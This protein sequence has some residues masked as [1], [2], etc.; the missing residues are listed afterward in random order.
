MGTRIRD[1]G[2]EADILELGLVD[3]LAS[4]SAGRGTCLTGVE[5][6]GRLCGTVEVLS[7]GSVPGAAVTSRGPTPA[8]SRRSARTTPG[9][10]TLAISNRRRSAC[11]R[12]LFALVRCGN[13]VV[14]VLLG[15]TVVRG[16]GDIASFGIAILAAHDGDELPDDEDGNPTE[17]KSHDAD[18]GDAILGCTGLAVSDVEETHS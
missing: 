8:V 7:V 14:R 2:L 16:D 13:W 10:P 1:G 4:M 15:V 12:R 6:L 9:G 18:D 17:G 5:S 11:S 3:S